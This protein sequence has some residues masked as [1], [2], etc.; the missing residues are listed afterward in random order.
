MDL[1]DGGHGALME[2]VGTSGRTANQQFKWEMRINTPALTAKIMTAAARAS[3]RRQ[4]R[5]KTHMENP[6]F[7]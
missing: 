2:R 3:F 4:P 1:L 5:A 7:E 6:L